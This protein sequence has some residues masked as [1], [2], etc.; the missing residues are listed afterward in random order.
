MT[1][2]F[3][4]FFFSRSE[5]ILECNGSRNAVNYSVLP[6]SHKKISAF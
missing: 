6:L 1:A 2:L 5:A 4:F 3:S